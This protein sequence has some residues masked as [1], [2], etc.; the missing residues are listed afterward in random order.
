MI[1]IGIYVAVELGKN[2]EK[3]SKT[4]GIFAIIGIFFFLVA[5]AV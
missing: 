5:F 3:S 1:L 4:A 2:M